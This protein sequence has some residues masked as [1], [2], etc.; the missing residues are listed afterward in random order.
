MADTTDP[1][2]V[3]PAGPSPGAEPAEAP[4]ALPVE[5]REGRRD[6]RASTSRC[7]VCPG[8]YDPVTNGHLDVIARAAT[9]FEEVIVAVLQNPSKGGVFTVEERVEMITRALAGEVRASGRVRVEAVGGGLLVDYCRSV[10]A[11]AVVKG[12][13][14]PDDFGYEL[15]MALMNRHLTGLETAFLAG[16]PAYGHVSSSLVKE[17]AAHGGDVHGLVPDLVADRLAAHRGSLGGP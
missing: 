17:V 10:G 12:L 2:S 14:G 3:A 13:R 15:P 8:S 5:R 11:V 1:T 4:V 16:D 9:L 6:R 7:C